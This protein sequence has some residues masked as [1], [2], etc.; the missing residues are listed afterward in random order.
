MFDFSL[1]K[2]KFSHVRYINICWSFTQD[3]IVLSTQFLKG[4]TYMHLAPSKLICLIQ[5]C[6]SFSGLRRHSHRQ[7][8]FMFIENYHNLQLQY[9]VMWQG[10]QECRLMNPETP[11]KH[12]LHQHQLIRCSEHFPKPL[13]IKPSVL[14]RFVFYAFDFRKYLKEYYGSRIFTFE[15]KDVEVFCN[16]TDMK[17]TKPEKKLR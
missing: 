15:G 8:S 2:L 5:A 10:N 7:L 17:G 9:I 12:F 4:R 6:V 13:K 16:T 14:V 1:Y 11:Q 3:C